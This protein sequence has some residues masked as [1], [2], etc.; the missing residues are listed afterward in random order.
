MYMYY[1]DTM[2]QRYHILIKRWF[3]IY[4][5]IPVFVVPNIKEF[6]MGV[7]LWGRLN[8]FLCDCEFNPLSRMIFLRIE[9]M[10]DCIRTR[11]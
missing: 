3:G 6:F 10:K 2:H 8:L 11:I 4:I 1:D 7:L 5:L 9:N